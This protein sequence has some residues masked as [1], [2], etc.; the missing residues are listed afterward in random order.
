MVTGHPVATI[1]PVPSTS[2]VYVAHASVYEFPISKVIGVDPRSVMI[3][4]VVSTALSSHGVAIQLLVQSAGRSV[5]VAPVLHI[6]A[7]GSPSNPDQIHCSHSTLSIVAAVLSVRIR[8]SHPLFKRR[9][10]LLLKHHGESVSSISISSVFVG[11]FNKNSALSFH[12]TRYPRA[13][14][15]THQ[16]NT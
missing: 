9:Q 10:S 7:H 2:S 15:L 1:L 14:I 8:E 4:A 13:G 16:V 12:T 3:G 11:Y 5:S 6:D